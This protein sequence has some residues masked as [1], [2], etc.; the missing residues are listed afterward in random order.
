MSYSYTSPTKF[1]QYQVAEPHSSLMSLHRHQG[2]LL[3]VVDHEPRVAVLDQEDLL[4]QGI[5]TAALVPGAPKV[6][7]LGSCTQQANTEALSNELEK[8]TFLRITGASSYSDTKACQEFSIR[9]YARCTHQTGDPSQEWPPT[10]CGS[11]GVYVFKDDLA[12][13]WI[14][15]QA[16]AH[17]AQDIVSLM[18]RNGLL[19]GQPWL[20]AWMTPGRNAFIDGDGS[21]ESLEA[22][23]RS[24]VAGGHETYW[25]AIER[26]YLTATDQVDPFRTILR[27]RNSWGLGFG[28]HGSY[29]FHLSTF[30]ML[31]QYV[32][33]RQVRA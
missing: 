18:Q 11:S 12:Q 22:A 30:V 1:G 16:I 5:D 31:G 2:E 14:T 29:R 9:N 19:V 3:K 32:D 28:D 7:A 6:D 17:G 15:S 24:G 21:P 20:N 8:A 25:A 33:L 13:G 27:A 26:L 4:A 23:L 10:D